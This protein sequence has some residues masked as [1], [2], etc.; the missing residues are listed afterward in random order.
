[1]KKKNSLVKKAMNSWLH[2]LKLRLKG[3]HLPHTLEKMNRQWI[4]RALVKPF[5]QDPG[6]HKTAR[7]STINECPV[8][9]SCFIYKYVTILTNKSKK[10]LRGFMTIQQFSIPLSLRIRFFS[11]HKKCEECAQF[12][13]PLIVPIKYNVAGNGQEFGSLSFKDPQDISWQK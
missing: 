10:L 13:P 8:V 7:R 9:K 12:F 2:Q 5:N 4:P 6:C 3:M 1:M 11:M